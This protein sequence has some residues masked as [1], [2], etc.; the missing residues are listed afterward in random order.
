MITPLE[1]LTSEMQCSTPSTLRPGWK[2]T[3]T[4]KRATDTQKGKKLRQRARPRVM[5]DHLL[6]STGESITLL[7]RRALR[8]Q[9]AAQQYWDA[10]SRFMKFCS[11]RSLL[12]ET[13]AQVDMLWPLTPTSCTWME[14]SITSPA[15]GTGSQ[16]MEKSHPRQDKQSTSVGRVG[17]FVSELDQERDDS[18]RWPLSVGSCDVLSSQRVACSPTTRHCPIQ[19]TH[20]EGLVSS[21]FYGGT[22]ARSTTVLQD[23]CVLLDTQWMHHLPKQIT[24]LAK[25]KANET[26]W[27]FFYPSLNQ[28]VKR[29]A[30]RLCLEDRV[31]PCQIRHSGPSIDRTGNFRILDEVRL[32]G[33]CTP[34][35]SVL[36]Y[37]MSSKFAADY[38]AI[39]ARARVGINHTPV[40]SWSVSLATIEKVDS[41]KSA[42]AVHGRD[43]SITKLCVHGRQSI[44]APLFYF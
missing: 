6:S 12:F 40:V 17:S 27:S 30:K 16:R 33:A 24:V 32:P 25:G 44:W 4:A 14:S 5:V 39:P 43:S 20:D 34:M 15:Q 41:Q 19:S 21:H 29:S 22:N 11:E 37:D 8:S 2:A 18:R 28:K 42:W 1:T 26:P 7:K 38:H 3:P 23:T 31:T 13:P 35:S 9:A 36:R 10:L